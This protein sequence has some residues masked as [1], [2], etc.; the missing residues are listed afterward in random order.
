MSSICGESPNNNFCTCIGTDNH[1]YIQYNAGGLDSGQGSGSQCCNLINVT[2]DILHRIP[3]TSDPIGSTSQFLNYFNT[4]EYTQ[5]NYTK[6]F[7]GNTPGTS[8]CD[9]YLK[10]NYSQLFT[11][12]ERQRQIYNSFYVIRDNIYPSSVTTNDNLIPIISENTISVPDG[13]M[14]L[15]L[16][17]FDGVHPQS[18]YL[19]VVWPIGRELPQLSFKNTFYYFYDINGKDCKS[20]YCTTLYS[21]TRGVSFSNIG[22]GNKGEVLTPG[23]ININSTIALICI[24]GLLILVISTIIIWNSY[25]YKKKPIREKEF[26][27]ISP[28]KPSGGI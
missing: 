24:I 20:S 15:V 1:E 21:P 23:D 6:Y 25:K 11:F 17:Y 19:F 5:C 4:L 13:C 22:P 8:D 26:T 12:A 2:P 18:Q 16:N 28:P 27:K 3:G 7:N 9:F 10:N 14:P